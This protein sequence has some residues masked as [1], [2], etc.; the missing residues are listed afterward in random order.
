MVFAAAENGWGPSGRARACLARPPR[1]RPRPAGRTGRATRAAVVLAVALLSGCYADLVVGHHATVGD[2]PGQGAGRGWSAGFA[3]GIELDVLELANLGQGGAVA[4]PHP[5]W[6]TALSLGLGAEDLTLEGERAVGTP[7]G[8]TYCI[9]QW[10]M[11][12]EYALLRF[13]PQDDTWTLWASLGGG[14]SPNAPVGWAVRGGLGLRLRTDYFSLRGYLEPVYA[15]AES[16]T[17]DVHT[18]GVQAR[19]RFHDS[20]MWI[21]R[22]FWIFLTAKPADIGRAGERRYAGGGGSSGSSGG[23]ARGDGG[24]ASREVWER[25]FRESEREQNRRVRCATL[26][27]SPNFN[28]NCY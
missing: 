9:S 12:L 2:P 13:R 7:W 25:S 11:G 24:N 10:Q 1:S 6:R 16:P 17:G 22:A 20:A 27:Q 3:F 15:A 8:G 21:G 23:Y 18:L 26:G 4:R 14:L 19:L 28:Q 5:L